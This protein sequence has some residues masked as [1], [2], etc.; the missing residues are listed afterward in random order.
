MTVKIIH[1]VAQHVYETIFIH[2]KTIEYFELLLYFGF[3]YSDFLEAV[4]VYIFC[5]CTV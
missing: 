1:D 3:F 5:I 2:S 4:H